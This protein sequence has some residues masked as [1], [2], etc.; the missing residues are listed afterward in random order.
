MSDTASIPSAATLANWEKK[1]PH[2]GALH[3]GALCDEEGMPPREKKTPPDAAQFVALES[4][5]KPT[6]TTAEASFY[7]NRREQTLRGWACSETGPL[8]PIRVHGR[9]AWRTNEIRRLLG[10]AA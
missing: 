9:L 10:V 8:R 1:E 2:V 7:L 6:L 3:V 4:V 5:T